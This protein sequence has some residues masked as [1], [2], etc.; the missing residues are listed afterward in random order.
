MLL[1]VD[2]GNTNT[3]FG[4]ADTAAGPVRE[5]ARISSDRVRTADEWFSLLLPLL[6]QETR[7][8]HPVERGLISS[9]V[10]AITR[11]LDDLCRR[12]FN[13][14]PLHV[15]V[16]LD[17][18]I[19]VDVDHPADVGADRLVNCAFGYATFGGPLIIVDLG[20]ATK[21]EA[22]SANGHYIG[23]SIAPGLGLTL[24][25]LATRAAR[26]FAVEL[27][28]PPSAIGRNT[29][30]AVQSGVVLGHIALVEG[31]IARIR[32]EL[33]GVRQV[34]LTGGFSHVLADQID[35]V[36]DHAPN[37]T[38]DGLLFLYQRNRP[39]SVN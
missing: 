22:I 24:D 36:T 27:K 15:S 10:P 30:A 14:V 19:T 3:V 31:L 2:V 28:S 11:Q 38:L 21:L 34:V 35:G 8:D 13:F 18:G 23:G 25:A 16:Q 9:V 5:V 37:L 7:T 26:L 29:V 4:I 6:P 32:C 17:L 1:L 20:T 33:D 12:H 39:E